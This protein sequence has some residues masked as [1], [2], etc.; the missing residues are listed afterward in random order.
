MIIAIIAAWMELLVLLVK[1]RILKGWSRWMKISPVV[2]WVL[3]QVLILLPLNV[4]APMGNLIVIRQSVPIVPSVSGIVTEVPIQS[5]VPLN[6]GDVLFKID[7][8]IYEAEVAR[9]EAQLV[10]DEAELKRRESIAGTGGVSLEE[11]G[12]GQSDVDQ[13]RSQL[14]A[15]R[16]N[17]EQT[18]VSAPSDGFVGSLTLRPGV[19]VVAN[20]SQV[21]SFID[22]DDQVVLLQ[23]QQNHLRNVRLEQPAEVILKLFPGRIFE[24]T[25]EKVIRA[26]PK[27][28]VSASGQ[29]IDSFPVTAEP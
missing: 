1:L 24:A 8:V 25:V 29:V 4:D 18:T 22:N 5:N 9:L 14:I 15:A 27:G 26:N 3:C 23:V 16:W 19:R 6:K 13:L 11:V 20:S 12:R 28:Q 2:I 7:P 10:Q 21:M 17:L